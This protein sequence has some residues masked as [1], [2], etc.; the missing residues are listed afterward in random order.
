MNIQYN[1]QQVNALYKNTV[2]LAENHPNTY[3]YSV[4]MCRNV[5]DNGRSTSFISCA[6]DFEI[7][8]KV[9]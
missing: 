2:C 9:T 7:P 1:D 5:N 6:L 8:S 3:G 4:S